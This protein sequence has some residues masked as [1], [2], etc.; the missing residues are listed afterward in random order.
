MTQNFYDKVAKKF[1]RYHT[2]ARYVKEFTDGDPEEVF[3][4]K[5]IE[6]SGKEKQALDMG[7][8]DGR[9]TLSMAR[10]FKRIV[11]IDSS[12]G[13]LA[14]A[15]NL[16]KEK[17]STNVSFEK[18]DAFKTSYSD[19][20]FDVIHGRR[21]PTPYSE[22]H[23]LLKPDGFFIEIGIGEQDTRSLMETFGRGQGYGEWDNP[24][25]PRAKKQVED[26]GF[27]IVYADEFFYHEYY[28]SYDD[29]DL[30]L[31]GVPIFEDFDSEKDKVNLQKYVKENTTDRGIRLKRHRTV[32]LV[33]KK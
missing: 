13:M 15:R 6:V 27:N 7:S 14:S 10:Y 28:A 32:V 30:F 26:L 22:I 19:G 9:F 24:R 11:A 2:G 20:S 16:Q 4:Q 8:A 31:Q 17:H 1:G 3:K 18:E 25:L 33:R 12:E 21:G 23:R 5:L 29:L